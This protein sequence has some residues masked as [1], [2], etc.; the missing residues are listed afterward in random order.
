MMSVSSNSNTQ[1]LSPVRRAV[2]VCKAVLA[3]ENQESGK[4]QKEPHQP[5]PEVTGQSGTALPS[6]VFTRALPRIPTVGIGMKAL[7]Q[8]YQRN[9]SLPESCP[10]ALGSRDL[11]PCQSQAGTEPFCS[12]STP[13][14]AKVERAPPLH[15]EGQIPYFSGLG[16]VRSRRGSTPGSASLSAE[17]VLGDYRSRK[18][19]PG[20]LRKT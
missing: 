17:V 1:V 7:L 10:E 5:C 6:S 18:H 16:P 8:D 3:K 13:G 19:P 15:P 12:M 11:H 14:L 9:T 2:E 4:P 20:S